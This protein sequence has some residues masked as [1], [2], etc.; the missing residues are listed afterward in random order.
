MGR[1]HF[2]PIGMGLALRIIR[3]LANN[4]FAEVPNFFLKNK[5]LTTYRSQPQSKWVPMLSG[6]TYFMDVV[7]HK[8]PDMITTEHGGFHMVF[9]EGGGKRHLSTHRGWG[10]GPRYEVLNR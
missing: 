7:M 3:W 8:S 5:T 10:Y 2:T 6:T 1:L 9:N 4:F